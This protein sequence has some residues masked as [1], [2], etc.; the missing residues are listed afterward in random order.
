MNIIFLNSKAI[1]TLRRKNN[2]NITLQNYAGLYK[3]S[4]P[5]STIINTNFNA[6]ELFKIS[7]FYVSNKYYFITI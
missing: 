7:T 4:L 6:G 2:R 5:F 1:L 3:F